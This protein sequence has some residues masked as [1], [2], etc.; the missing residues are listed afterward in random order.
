MHI[1][2]TAVVA[3]SVE[4]RGTAWL[5][6][7]AIFLG[8]GLAAW[9]VLRPRRKVLPVFAVGAV[10]LV[11]VISS[12]TMSGSFLVVLPIVLGALVVGLLVGSSHRAIGRLCCSRSRGCLLAFFVGLVVLS[13]RGEQWSA[14]CLR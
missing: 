8:V 10:F 4:L 2:A 7:A 12:V 5:G 9:G 14:T 11:L 3:S 1:F 13:P 6:V